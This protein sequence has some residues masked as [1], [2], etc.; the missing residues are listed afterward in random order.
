MTRIPLWYNRNMTRSPQRWQTLAPMQ[1]W[2]LLALGILLL[3]ALLAWLPLKLSLLML[4]TLGF[5][6]ALLLRP[7]VGLYA[8]A[9]TIPFNAVSKIAMGS[10][11]IGA[12]DIL[13][14]GTFFAWFLRLA[15][16]HQRPRPARLL[17]FLLPFY[18]ALLYSTLAARSLVQALPELI[19]W[20]EVILIYWL[21]VQLLTPGHRL[22][23]AL[24]LLAAGSIEALIGIRQFLLR[25]GPDA[26]LLGRF[27]R[28]YGTFGQPNP[29]AGY[30]GLTLPLGL[31]LSL[32]SLTELA[33]ARARTLALRRRATLAAGVMLMSS[34]IAAGII[35]SW[36]RGAWLGVL[37]SSAAV[38]ALSS[39]VGLGIL[40]ALTVL[41]ILGG[42]LLPGSVS[43]R[44]GAIVGYFGIWNVRGIPV[45]DDNFAVLERVAHWQ[46]AWEM[47]ADHFWLGVGV[48]NWDV[49]YPEYAIGIWEASLGHAHNVLFHYAAV[50]GIAGA[51]SYVWLWLGSLWQ[52]LRAGS[53]IRGHERAIA[54]GV[55]GMLIHLSIHNQ[56]DN[57]WVQGMPLLIAL[58]LAILPLKNET[59]PTP[60]SSNR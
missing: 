57:L 25:I 48:G 38:L 58:G 59:K 56:F 15:A 30:L 2:R 29:Y 22:P 28:A 51:L 42:S 5:V 21:G 47:F 26:Y 24:T 33:R 12:T 17:W 44:L 50:A 60:S 4:A 20:A 43:G 13:V 39:W 16:F 53:R 55:S 11:S 34:L 32:W 18:I 23:L 49:T 1:H 46:A 35:V 27:L 9:L 41:L 37:A 40:L 52:A 8:L 3:A 14:A 6:L 10:V 31:S 19:K 7:V 45:N 54:V 36:S